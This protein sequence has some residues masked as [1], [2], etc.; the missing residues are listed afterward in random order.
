M[1]ASISRS[2][3]TSGHLALVLVIQQYQYSHDALRNAKSEM[4]SR[5]LL[6]LAAPAVP[7]LKT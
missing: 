3:I 4:K 7:G 2:A 5:S 1:V 6:S